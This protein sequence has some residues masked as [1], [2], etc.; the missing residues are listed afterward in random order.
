[1]KYEK[2]VL[3]K[4]NVEC[5][6]RNGTKEDGKAVLKTFNQTHEETEN[7]LTY[8]EENSFTE[9]QESA[10]L[11][12]KTE[13]EREIEIVAVVGGKIVGTAGIEA[14]GEKI[15]LRHRAEFGIG[16]EKEYWGLGIGRVLTAACIECAK[17]AGYTQLELDVVAEN[18]R[19]VELYKSFG[20]VEY[21]RNKRGFR[22]RDGDYQPLVY[23][24]LEL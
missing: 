19:A 16:I 21:G 23:M 3:L 8:P 14:V 4:N 13:S 6:L 2:T 11:K 10:F 7:L 12:E 17:K 5:V 18:E 20:F 15:K 24:L 1:M 9:E 22:K